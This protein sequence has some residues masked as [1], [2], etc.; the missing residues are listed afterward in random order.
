MTDLRL[1]I[2]D[3]DG[4]L[5]DSQAH[6][7]AAMAQAFAA[8]GLSTP[9]RAEI[10]QIVGLSLPVA[11]ARL[12]PDRPDLTAP[13]VEAYKGAFAALRVAD[14]DAALSPLFP[15]A[16]DQLTGLAA[17]D[18]TLLGVATGKSRRGLTHLFEMHDIAPL[19]HT[20]Q[21]ADDHPSK[22]HPAMIAACLLETGVAADHAVILGDTTY[23]IQMG[24]AAGIHA[25]GVAWGYHRPEALM[26]AGACAVLDRFDDLPGALEK[27]FQRP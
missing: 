12:A 16:R 21:V 18:F 13:L 26:A 22:P 25:L 14:D 2:F 19:F 10:L 27:V 5:V 11:M 4:T 3:V 17:Q 7:L 20:V 24:R 6:I 9:P 15:G 23:D 1:V 8:N